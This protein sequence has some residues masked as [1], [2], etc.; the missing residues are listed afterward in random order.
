MQVS[1]GVFAAVDEPP[2]VTVSPL[3]TAVEILPLELEVEVAGSEIELVTG[4]E[5]VV[6]NA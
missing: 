1:S 4:L 6:L 5:T 2:Q 3:M